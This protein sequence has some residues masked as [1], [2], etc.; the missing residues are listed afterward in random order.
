MDPI[1]ISQNTRSS[2]RGDRSRDRSRDTSSSSQIDLGV[3]YLHVGLLAGAVPRDV[4]CLAALVACLA[5]GAERT[6]VGSRAVSRDVT[7]LATSVALHGLRLTVTSEVVGTTALVACGGARTAAISAT[8]VTP[9]ATTTNGTSTT[10]TNASGV[11]ASTSQVA[12]LP[13]V[14][15]P[16]RTGAAQSQGWAVGLYVTQS[17]TVVALFGLSRSGKRA[18]VRLVSWL[19]AVVAKAFSR[20]ANFGIVTDVATFVAGTARERRHLDD[21]SKMMMRMARYAKKIKNSDLA[22]KHQLGFGL[23]RHDVQP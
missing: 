5:S 13:T 3:V 19:L 23:L 8:A 16:T 7:K 22:Q 11:G 1:H 20:G 4:A 10:H 2:C 17:L 18:L 6:S 9:K 15:T 14:V 12:R 21:L